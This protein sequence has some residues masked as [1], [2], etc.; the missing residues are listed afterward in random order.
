MNNQEMKPKWVK[1]ANQ[2]TV[3][4]FTP[5]KSKPVP[6]QHQEWFATKEQAESFIIKKQEELQNDE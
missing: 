4:Y 2:W 3:T 5:Q 6:L 1:R